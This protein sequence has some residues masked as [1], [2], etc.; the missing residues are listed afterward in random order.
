M[1]DKVSWVFYKFKV[2]II[3]LSIKIENSPAFIFQG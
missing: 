3:S 1:S 2:K